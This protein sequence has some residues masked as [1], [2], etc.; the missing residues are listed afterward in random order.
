MSVSLVD[1]RTRLETLAKGKRRERHSVDE[2]PL[3]ANP[4]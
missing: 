2:N 3:I 1:T 4:Q